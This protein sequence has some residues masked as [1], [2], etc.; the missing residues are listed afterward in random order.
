MSLTTR[1]IEFWTGITLLIVL[2]S[3]GLQ[4]AIELDP[5]RTTGQLVATLTQF[6]YA[7]T[8][9]LAAGALLAR[10]SW[11]L[12]VV[13]LWAGLLTFTAGL[14]PVVWGGAAPMAG[15]VAG[16]AIGAIAVLVVWLT[17]RRRAA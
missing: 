8:G 13:W 16:L 1:S 6:G 10:R 11:A 15:V 4:S 5:A 14:V 9:A 7:V 2:S 3:L 12:G 17:S